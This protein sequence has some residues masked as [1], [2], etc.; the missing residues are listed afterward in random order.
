MWMQ[1]NAQIKHHN[2]SIDDS[3]DASALAYV[4]GFL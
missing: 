4:S 3:S 2:T 1:C